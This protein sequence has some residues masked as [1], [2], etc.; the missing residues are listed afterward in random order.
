[1]LD[2]DE[3]V[4]TGTIFLFGVFGFNAGVFGAVRDVGAATGASVVLGDV[5]CFVG[6]SGT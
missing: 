4:G 3:G 1:V 6:V 2:E 5:G